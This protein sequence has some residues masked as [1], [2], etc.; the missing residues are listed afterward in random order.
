MVLTIWVCFDLLGLPVGSA[1]PLPLNSGALIPKNLRIL[2][3]LGAD[4][5]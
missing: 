1:G 5:E 4:K 2:L 3:N